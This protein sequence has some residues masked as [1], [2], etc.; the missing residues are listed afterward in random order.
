LTATTITGTQVNGDNL[1]LDGNTLSSTDTNGNIVIAPNGTGQVQ[2]SGALDVTD[3]EVT[4]IKAKDGTAA[5][6]IADSTGAVTVATALTANGGAVFNENGANVDFRVEGD[7]DANLLFVDASADAVGIGTATVTSGY[8]LEVSGSGV[9]NTATNPFYDLYATG[10]ATNAKWWRVGGGGADFVVTAINDAGSG[11]D[12]PY[13]ITRS[14]Q[15]AQT[16][17]WSTASSERMRLTSTGTLNIVGA[18]TAGTSQA[19]SI[20]GS[21]PVNTLVTTSGGNVG[22]GT[23]SPTTAYGYTKVIDIAGSFPGIKFTPSGASTFGFQ[24]GAGTSGFQFY[25]VAASAE[26]MRIDSSGNLGIGTTSPGAKLTIGAAGALRLNRS[27]NAT[28]GEIN[29]GGS[30]VGIKFNDANSDGYTF[31]NGG[32]T[33]MRLDSSGNLGIGVTPSA[34]ASGWTC[35]QVGYSYSLMTASLSTAANTWYQMN[36]AY[37][38]GSFKYKNNGFACSYEQGSGTHIW[39]TAPSGTAGNAITFTQAMTLDASGN[40]LLATTSAPTYGSKLRVQG[41]IESWASQFNAI[42]G[43]N[44]AFE[45]VNRSSGGSIDFYPAN[46]FAARITS[47]GD[48][49]VGTNANPVGAGAKITAVNSGAYYAGSFVNDNKDYQTILVW[50]KATTGTRYLMEFGTGSTYVAK[51]SITTDGTNTAYNTS[52]DYRLKDNQQPL[53]GSGDFIDALKPKTWNWKADGSKGVGFIAHEVQ[54]VSPGS[55]VG[56]KDA[57]DEDGNPIMQAMEYGSAE[58]IANIIAE[59]Q[60]LRARVAQLEGK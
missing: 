10:Q 18:G 1:R 9:R 12:T 33:V 59:L 38:D 48:L 23:D 22:I 34:W 50:N 52:S 20:N 6:S 55:V 27:D 30:G 24:I 56:E 11:S 46:S 60:S 35:Q 21:T 3:I 28:Y 53:T 29:Y 37:Y 16:H 13:R 51:G 39:K 26:R 25:D 43:T 44:T 42:P 19:V 31:Q 17:Q 2:L 47:G 15:V 57:V 14:A 32:S 40:L 54:A 58:F 8:K 36:N 49:Y 4:N 5:L 41:G 45:I 7:T